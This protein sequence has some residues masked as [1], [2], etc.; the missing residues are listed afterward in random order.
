MPMK[1]EPCKRYGRPNPPRSPFDEKHDGN[2]L[3]EFE[4]VVVVGL[5]FIHFYGTLSRDILLDGEQTI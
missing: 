4:N 5:F 1:K 3:T 2:V